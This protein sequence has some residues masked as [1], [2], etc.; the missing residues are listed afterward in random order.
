MLAEF[1]YTDLPYGGELLNAQITELLISFVRAELPLPKVQARSREEVL[2]AVLSEMD[3]RMLELCGV[4][5]LASHFGYT[6]GHL[7][8]LFREAYGVT[9]GEYLLQK[10]MAYALRELQRGRTVGECAALLGYS[11]AYNFSR[12][13][14]AQTGR[15]PSTCRTPSARGS[16][17]APAAEAERKK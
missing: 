9:P 4:G 3:S 14:K 17:D 2:S 8:K 10:K 13:F 11:S 5:E 7:C 12:A 16:T 1:T 15:A 6:A